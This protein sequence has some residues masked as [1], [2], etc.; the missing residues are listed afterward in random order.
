MSNRLPR[1]RAAAAATAMALVLV[2]ASAAAAVADTG[3]AGV[4][5]AAAPALPT[6]TVTT[7][8]A[9]FTH[10]GIGVTAQNLEFAR[11]Q[12]RAGVQPWEGYFDALGVSKYASRTLQSRNKGNVLDQ[13]AQ[14]YFTSTSTESKLIEDSWGAFA[15]AVEYFM[16]GDNTYR[17]N[18]M[19]II[20]I[21]SNMDPNRYAYY[22]D[23]QI[24]TGVPLYRLLA[25]AEILRYTSY[26]SSYSGYD[27]AWRD[28]DTDKLTTN[29]IDP[30]AKVFLYKNTNY[31]NQHSYPL[32]GALAG[33]IFTDNRPRYDE[34]VEWYTVNA[35]TTRPEQNGALAAILPLI[36]KNDPLNPYGY[37]FVQHQEMG[38]DQAHGGDDVDN[39]A[40][41]ARILSVQGTKID[42]EHGT[43]STASD[44]V[45]PYRFLSDR[46]LA[47][48]DAYARFMLGYDTPWIDT[49]G[50]TG[51]ISS[52]YRGR[53]YQ[54]AEIDELY[55]VYK[56][57]EGVDVEKEA[58]YLAKAHE[59]NYGPLYYAGST[60]LN[61]FWSG[62]DTGP[63]YWLSFPAEL[64][65]QSPVPPG[66]TNVQVEQKGVAFDPG[67]EM[68]TE[69]GRSFAEM[70]ASDRGTT[71]V[72]HDLV[73]GNRNNYCPVGV[74]IRTT[75]SGMRLA[76]ARDQHTAPFRTLTLPN[77]HGEWRYVTYDV[78]YTAVHANQVGDN[79]A[80]FTVTGPEGGTVDVDHVN[81]L[82]PSQLTPPKFPQ[83]KSTDVIAVTKE[84]LTTS[85]AATD[86]GSKDTV[87]YRAEGL[88]EGA[89]LDPATGEFNWTPEQ[90][91]S[92]TYHFSV[93]AD[94]G[95]VDTVLDVTLRAEPNRQQAYR[96]A[97][98]GYDPKETY[99]T[100]SLADFTKV[101]DQVQESIPTADEAEFS[102]SLVTLQAAVRSLQLLNP[103]LGD[104]S[105]DYPSL[106][107]SS[108]S[109]LNVS[110]LVDDDWNTTT[111]DLKAP[112]TV[113]FGAGYRVSASDFGL[114]ARYNFAN[115]SEGA[116]VYGSNDGQNWTLL[117]SRET[118][119]TTDQNF[120]METI[121]ALPDVQDLQFRYF[122]VQIDDP[123]IPTDPAYPGLS[124]FSEFRIHG[125]RHEVQS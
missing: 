11:K 108:L 74:L 43:V 116:N 118:T 28:S 102:T 12:V 59:Q 82:A 38:R 64:A 18:A 27:L 100:A 91:Q 22:A 58:P 107:T 123:G 62:I 125:V 10:P 5:A 47:G 72:V 20:R 103:V 124:S 78:A 13:P 79:I 34:G 92:G 40:G 65:G 57:V 25:A 45:D 37:S 70:H 90:R 9:G 77:T 36:D 17:A 2:P 89:R 80:Y 41:L 19:K 101:R 87:S 7:S 23:S 106:V 99:T 15:Q 75:T 21:W 51:T 111:G 42:P 81:T 39:L 4:Q 71:L 49:T 44:A 52:A 114:Q 60:T 93:I 61:N 112:F 85:F 88:P 1:L 35:T 6:I 53:L 56:Y 117:T 121:P 46:L 32:I 96:E 109:A 68:R 76:V 97:L 24:H 14:P 122:K 69:D 119:N 84:T 66:D 73:Y 67:T 3:G 8:G 16:T 54:V 83:G 113:D 50:G 55:D 86:A 63:E 95:T 29:L 104:G 48:A 98:T 31:L 26:D 33:Y 110:N 115:R 30:M 120:A 94:D 105:L